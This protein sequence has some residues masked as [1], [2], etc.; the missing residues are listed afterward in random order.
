MLSC[1]QVVQVG[2]STGLSG[3]GGKVDPG[4]GGGND[5]GGGGGGGGN[6][7]PVAVG[8]KRGVKVAVC[9]ARAGLVA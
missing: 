8:A 5:P 9:P 6:R 4:G 7:V 2:S 1:K 3:G